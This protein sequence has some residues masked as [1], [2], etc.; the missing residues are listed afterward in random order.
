MLMP[1]RELAFGPDFNLRLLFIVHTSCAVSLGV[2]VGT[3]S[4]GADLLAV[5]VHLFWFGLGCLMHAER[6]LPAHAIENLSAVA[7]AFG[8]MLLLFSSGL[9]I[10]SLAAVACQ[11]IP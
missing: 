10:I 7:S 6:R 2:A 9:G 8:V 11:A 1:H 3:Q 5:A 4:P